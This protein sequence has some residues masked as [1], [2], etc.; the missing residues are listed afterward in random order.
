MDAKGRVSLPSKF[1]GRLTGEVMLVK[2][3]DGCVWLFPHKEYEQ[4]IGSVNQPEALFNPKARKAQQFFG[5][6]S[7]EI[8][9]DS[10]GRIRI[11][12]NLREHAQLAKDLT[13]AGSFDRIEIWDSER[14]K[15][16]LDELDIDELTA[17]LSAEGKL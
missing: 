10:A 2:G 15:S 7:Q 5:A 11:P 16:Y 14:Y 8:E 13:I 6:G 9:I 17:N 1:R 4:F 12:A 3:L